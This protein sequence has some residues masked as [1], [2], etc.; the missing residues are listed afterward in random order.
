MSSYSVI[1]LRGFRALLWRLPGAN[2]QVI[3]VS[4]VEFR[5]AAYDERQAFAIVR[6]ERIVEHQL[7]DATTPVSDVA[8]AAYREEWQRLRH[9]NAPLRVLTD[10]GLV[11]APIDHFDGRIRERIT[12]SWQTCGH[13]VGDTMGT[14]PKFRSLAFIFVRLLHP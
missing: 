5:S 11:S 10:D 14:L 6:A 12:D 2:I 3:D 13:V 4:T 7:L 9:E 1:E 8:R